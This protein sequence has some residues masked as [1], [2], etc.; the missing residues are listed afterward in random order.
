M[1]SLIKILP[2]LLVLTGSAYGYHNYTINSKESQITQ[3]KLNVNTLQNN[4]IRLESA[5][6]RS[7][8]SIKDALENFKKQQM[9]IGEMTAKNEML[10]RERDEYLSIFKRHDLTNL[11]RVKPGLI[12]PRI[13]NGTKTV[14]RQIE[15]DSKEIVNA[16]D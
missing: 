2:I 13:N 1:F 14:F 10:S 9:T 12:E 4:V 15:Q 6:Q 5:L 11:A 16:N 7:E 8:Q 3:L